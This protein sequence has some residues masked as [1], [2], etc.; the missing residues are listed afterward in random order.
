MNPRIVIV[1]TATGSAERAWLQ[2]V[3][4]GFVCDPLDEAGEALMRAVHAGM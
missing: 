3:G 4:A 1:A 2:E